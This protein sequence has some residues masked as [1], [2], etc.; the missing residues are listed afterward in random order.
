MFAFR[1]VNPII[2]KVIRHD[3]NSSKRVMNIVIHAAPDRPLQD[4]PSSRIRID[5][6]L[7]PI[8]IHEGHP[9]PVRVMNGYMRRSISWN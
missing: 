9:H 3:L 7:I 8:A 5:H 1:S 6:I 2:V 4:A